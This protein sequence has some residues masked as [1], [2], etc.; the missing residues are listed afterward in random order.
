MK[1]VLYVTILEFR[2]YA[3]NLRTREH[4]DW[5]NGS[6]W[7]AD[8]PAHV[9]DWIFRLLLRNGHLFWG[10]NLIRLRAETIFKT[11]NKSIQQEFVCIRGKPS[12]ERLRH[13]Y[14]TSVL[15]LVQGN[16]KNLSLCTTTTAAVWQW[17]VDLFNS[18]EASIIFMLYIYVTTD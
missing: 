13:V 12:W 5:S 7:C 2:F 4:S 18:K 10:L 17:F 15:Q 6:K 11:R 3:N 1:W 16:C 14:G 8:F 9:C